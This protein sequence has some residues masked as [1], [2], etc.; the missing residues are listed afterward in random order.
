M[1]VEL[2]S[3]RDRTRARELIEQSGLRFEENFQTLVGVFANGTLVATAARDRNV[4]KMFAVRAD[5]QGGSL[6][7]ELVTEL[8]RGGYHAGFQSFFVFTPPRSAPSFQA[9]NFTPL[10][11]HHKVSLLEYG[12][13]LADYLEKHRPLVRHGSNGA[14]VVNCNPFT[15][16]HLYL[17]EEA[18]RRVDHL[19]IFVVREDR[20]IFPFE[21]RYRLVS[22][23]VKH[24]RKVSVLDS[25]DYAVSGVTFP[26]YFLKEDDDSQALQIELDLVLFAKHIAPA[27]N[28]KKRF[29]GT[30]PYCR[31]TRLYSE[32]MHRVLAPFGLETVQL[33]RKTRDGE[34]ISAFRVREALRREAYQT[35]QRLVP[36]TTMEFLRSR[37]ARA[38]LERL[39]SQQRR[40]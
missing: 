34:A 39:Q 35:V 27:F 30:E 12:N 9:L 6:L 29:I 7:G 24:L 14:V 11:N 22:E 21:V 20:S 23:G 38:I 19:Y 18:A 26:S 17:I 31:T 37:E 3:S 33:Q 13:G 16:G 5:F 1:V 36:P 40:H 4:F 10:L 25:S 2:I 8:V 28:I 32:E 15:L